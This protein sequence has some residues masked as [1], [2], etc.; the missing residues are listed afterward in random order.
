M[1]ESGLTTG[2]RAN[3]V[4]FAMESTLISKAIM[5]DVSPKNRGECRFRKYAFVSGRGLFG[6]DFRAR[7]LTWGSARGREL[8]DS[9]MDKVLE[10]KRAIVTGSTSGIGLGIA[11]ALA[12]AGCRLTVNGFGNRDSIEELCSELTR[13]SGTEVVHVQ[14]DVSDETQVEALVTDVDT[15]LGGVDILVNNAGVQHVAPVEEFSTERW[16][17]MIA[18]NLSAAFYGI[19]AVMPGMKRRDWGRV[20]NVASA[21]GLVASANKAGYVAAKH[22]V[23]G[24]TKVVALENARTGITCNA[25]C[26]GWVR[27]PLLEGQLEARAAREGTSVEAAA[28]ALL[29]EKH[30]NMAFVEAAD[31]GALVVW[32][33]G[34][35]ARSMTGV[36]IS[37]DGG[38]TTQ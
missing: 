6:T 26:P 27:T 23:I 13:L 34:D 15:R 38:W 37:M 32:I 22:G 12:G 20:V 11:W 8:G 5:P 3:S 36:A 9:A 30:P 7:N 1:R 29:A 10:G 25:V 35:A 19:R 4:S 33:C 24:L 2:L 16:D 31:I 17:A 18:V 14:A 21:H 28:Q